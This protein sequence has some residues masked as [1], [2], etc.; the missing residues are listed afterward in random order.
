[1]TTAPERTGLPGADAGAEALIRE[2][3]RRQRRRWLASGA[4]VAAAVAAVAAVVAGWVGGSGRP[5][6][7]QHGVPAAPAHRPA[8]GAH[9][10][11]LTTV[12]QTSL[13]EGNSLSL[14]VGY[15]AVWV[16]GIGVT[17]EVNQ[18]TGRIVRTISTPGTF[19]D[20]CGSGIAA[21]AGGVWVTHGCQG[22]Y[23]IDP[24]SGQVT[25]SLRVPDAGDAIAAAGGLVWVT[26]YRGDL[27]RIEPQTGK[28]IGKPVLRGILYAK[29][30]GDD[31]DRWSAS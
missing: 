19:P 31:R 6:P 27:L 30:G 16:T 20:G 18:V 13:P 4:A 10:V 9:A 2:A 5:P 8:A 21:G 26:S 15:R 25:A 12:S 22:V 28:I 14:A 3:R 7:G 24:R 1:V 17:Y 11:A 29:Q 23:R